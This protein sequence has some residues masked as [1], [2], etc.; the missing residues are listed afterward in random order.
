MKWVPHSWQVDGMKFLVGQPHGAIWLPMGMGKSATALGAL[1]AL[2]AR[3]YIKRTLIVAPIR[4]I[5]IVWPSEVALWD[6]FKHLRIVNLRDNVDAQWEDA[7]IYLINPEQFLKWAELSKRRK[8]D[9]LIIDEAS[10]WKAPDSKRFKVLRR[11]LPEFSRRWELTGTPIPNGYMDLWSQMFILDQGAALGRYITHFRNLFCHTVAWDSFTYYFSDDAKRMIEDRIARLVFRRELGD[12]GYKMPQRVDNVITVQMPPKAQQRY[13]EME[14]EFYTRLE[15]G[16][17]ITASHAAV[18][19][20]RCRQIASGAIY[21]ES[22]DTA[23]VHGAK[24]AAM[25]ELLTL[26]EGRPVLIFYEFKHEAERVCE[27]R[28]GTPNLSGL[29]GAA[30]KQL[31][32]DFNAGKIPRMLAHP[33]SAG[34]GLNLQQFCKDVIWFSPTWNLAHFMQAIARVWRMGQKETVTVHHV[35]AAGTLDEVVTSALVDKDATQTTLMKRIRD[36]A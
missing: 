27:L 7:D 36:R 28:P 24:V 25:E 5:D 17:E 35:I 34:F 18:A 21:D 4:V 2:R 10:L 16:E 23:F 14:K 13:A 15:E 32:A 20:L 1:V 9:H 31:V 19:S 30:M 11:L 26:L 12:A 33:A 6:D 29:S 22:G 3:G 8:F